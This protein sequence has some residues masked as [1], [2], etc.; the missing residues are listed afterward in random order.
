LVSMHNGGLYH[1]TCRM[2]DTQVYPSPPSPF[3]RRPPS[4][5]YTLQAY[6]SLAL[7]L[8]VIVV[9]LRITRTLTG[10]LFDIDGVLVKGPKALPHAREALELVRS[11]NV[12][13]VFVTNNG[14]ELE[15]DR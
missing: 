11:Q 13:Y 12:P 9:F 14:M 1:V 6:A 3:R 4:L 8:V 7:Q 5:L 15:G 2:P 10:F